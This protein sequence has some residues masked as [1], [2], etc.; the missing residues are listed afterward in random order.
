MKS[1]C[2]R[3]LYSEPMSIMNENFKF[4]TNNEKC[5]IN[6]SP[7]EN[8]TRKLQS[9]VESHYAHTP[10]ISASSSPKNGFTTIEGS[11]LLQEELDKLKNEMIPCVKNS[12][13]ADGLQSPTDETISMFVR[14]KNDLVE[15][16]N[17]SDCPLK[18]EMEQKEENTSEVS[19]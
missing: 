10:T 11:T 6:D 17:K 4:P 5:K 16:T 2:D 7:K 14:V 19:D 3:K 9:P 12:I 13:S 18:P 15:S 8:V 1:K